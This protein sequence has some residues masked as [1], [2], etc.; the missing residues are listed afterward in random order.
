M[1]D[2]IWSPRASRDFEEIIEYIAQDSEPNARTVAAELMRTAES[3]PA[4]PYVG[5]M[6]P[7]YEIDN[8][9]ERLVCGYRLIYRVRKTAIEIVAIYRAV[10]LLPKRPPR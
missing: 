7:E 8:L 1:A 10:R 5:A 4:Q 3:L 2:L 6:V 9:R